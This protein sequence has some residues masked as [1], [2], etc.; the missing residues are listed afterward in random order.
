MEVIRAVLQPV[1]WRIFLFAII[2]HQLQRRDA[3]HALLNSD[4]KIVE[5]TANS[6][7]KL[8]FKTLMIVKRK[9]MFVYNFVKR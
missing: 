9:T 4:Q 1:W 8:F 3:F 5:W 2:V 7:Q 6:L